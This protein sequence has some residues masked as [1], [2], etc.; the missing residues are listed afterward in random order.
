[1]LLKIYRVA[2]NIYHEISGV[3]LHKYKVDLGIH[4]KWSLFKKLKYNRLGF[5]NEDYHNFDLKHNDYHDYI[6]FRERWR[7]ENINGRFAYILGE[8]LMFE[9]IFG[10]FINVP[11]INFW[12]KNGKFIDMDA[13]ETTDVLSVLKTKGE[14]IAKPTRSVGGGTGIHKIAFNGQN[15]SI[16]GKDCS[17]DERVKAVSSWEEYIVVDYIK[18]AEYSSKIYPE[19][20][21]SIRIVTARRKSGDYELLLAFH[22]FGS[23]LSRP[24]DNISSGGLG[25]FVDID[26]GCLEKAKRKTDPKIMHSVHP[27]SHGQIE[28]VAIPNWAD[29]KEKLLHVH[30]CFPF[31]VFLAWDVVVGENGEPYILEIN[32]GCDL[33]VQRA[34]PLRHEKLG[35]FMRE[36]GLLDNR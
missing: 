22:R 5:T 31:Y 20:T 9:R 30:R 36:Y 6:S 11:H 24:V 1:M 21:N 26:S 10:K 19:T 17:E 14:L 8:K 27:D 15:Y 28:G 13:G 34:K 4:D 33:G 3:W 16:D 2:K 23:D 29:I 12:V 25:A 7:L 35:E 32:R 18:Q